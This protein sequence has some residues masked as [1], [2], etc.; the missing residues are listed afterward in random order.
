MDISRSQTRTIMVGGIQHSRT[1]DYRSLDATCFR[2]AQTE[3][4][5][6]T[7]L[8]PISQFLHLRLRIQT[9]TF[10]INAMVR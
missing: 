8:F 7:D 2:L 1:A 6:L 9:K 5:G 4:I 3:Q 10:P